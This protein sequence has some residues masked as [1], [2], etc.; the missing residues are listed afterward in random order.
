[1]TDACRSNPL[2]GPPA[3]SPG[4]LKQAGTHWC[5]CVFTT[6]IINIQVSIPTTVESLKLVVVESYMSVDNHLCSS[7]F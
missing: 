5:K 4:H 6:T 1:M 3:D 7:I 2:S